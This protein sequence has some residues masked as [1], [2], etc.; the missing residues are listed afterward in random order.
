M[1]DLERRLRESNKLPDGKACGDCRFYSF[2][3]KLFACK[4]D[5]IEC[6]WTPSRFKANTEL[7]T[8]P[9]YD[10]KLAKKGAG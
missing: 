2:C 9:D 3:F 6:D 8:P 4:A 10:R 7:L 1:T 5:N